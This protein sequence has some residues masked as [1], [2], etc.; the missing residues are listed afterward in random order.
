MHLSN[1]DLQKI[2]RWFDISEDSLGDDDLILYDK[3]KDF[4]DEED[5]GEEEDLVEDVF[6]EDY[7]DYDDEAEED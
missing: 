5:S 6:E 2:L 3:I 1:S 7:S 4:I